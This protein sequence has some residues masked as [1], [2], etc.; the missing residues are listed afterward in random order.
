MVENDLETLCRRW[1][2]ADKTGW[3]KGLLAGVLSKEIARIVAGNQ[4]VEI[5]KAKIR[6]A[7]RKPVARQKPRYPYLVQVVRGMRRDV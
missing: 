5:S 4:I 3:S 6:T 7:L 2:E 1:D